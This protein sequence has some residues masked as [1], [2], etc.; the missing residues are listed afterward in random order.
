MGNLKIGEALALANATANKLDGQGDVYNT[1]NMLE[2]LNKTNSVR[3]ILS[4]NTY[5]RRIV[6]SNKNGNGKGIGKDIGKGNGVGCGTGKGVGCGIG[7]GNG[8]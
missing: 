2:K 6:E 8:Q 3:T 1:N 5:Y 4:L 7:K